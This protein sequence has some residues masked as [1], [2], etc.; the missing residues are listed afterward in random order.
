MRIHDRRALEE[1]AEFAL[2][3][4]ASPVGD[5]THGFGL[6]RR[7]LLTR[8]DAGVHDRVYRRLRGE[9]LSHPLEQPSLR[10]LAGKDDENGVRP[11]DGFV[12]ALQ[13]PLLESLDPGHVEKAH[14]LRC[15]DV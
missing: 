15:A 4:V 9:P 1:R 3:Q 12:D 14:R 5:L 6:E 11:A 13:Y 10:L 7:H 8:E 2:E